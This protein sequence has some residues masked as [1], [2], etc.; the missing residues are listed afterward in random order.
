MF[1]YRVGVLP[2]EVNSLVRPKDRLR[3]FLPPQRAEGPDYASAEV[4]SEVERQFG[5]K[6]PIS[7]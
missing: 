3:V 6:R 2:E 7:D 4:V 1:R 5:I